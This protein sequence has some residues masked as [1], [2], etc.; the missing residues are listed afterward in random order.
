VV[1]FGGEVGSSR[2]LTPTETTAGKPAQ[3][4]FTM[5]AKLSHCWQTEI[6][7]M[8]SLEAAP[9]YTR[10]RDWDAWSK[11]MLF[12]MVGFYLTGRSFSYLGIP[13]A[14]L[15]IGDLTLA[16]FVIFRPRQLFDRWFGALTGGGPLGAFSWVL[17]ISV[18]YGLFETIRG[19]LSGF[20]P[21][22]ALQNLVFN[23]YPLYFFLGLWAG[24]RRPELMLRIVQVFAW[25]LCIYGPFYYFFLHNVTT[26][27]PGSDSVTVFGQA[28]GGAFVILALLC[29]DPKPSRYWLPMIMAAVTFLVAQVRADWFGAVLAFSIWGVLE[30]K[31]KPVAKFVLGLAALLLIG[32]IFDV[33]LPSSSSRGGA[34]STREI[35]A[36]GL[37]AVDPELAKDLTGSEDTA[38]YAGTIQWR[39]KWWHAIWEN[40]QENKTNFVIGPGYGFE[41]KKLVSYLNYDIRTPHNIFYFALGYSGWLGV[42]IFFALQIACIS[43]LWRLYRV[44]GQAFGLAAY[45]ATLFSAFFGNVLEN[46]FGAIP[47]YCM[48]GLLIG[49]NVAAMAQGVRERVSLGNRSPAFAEVNAFDEVYA[50]E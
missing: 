3:N 42:C 15:F 43:M 24:A 45:S 29:L 5:P 22:I 50:G 33:N 7:A 39:E 9:Q 4:F 38:M 2:N 21:L 37:S 48:M 25:G 31:M 1:T 34:I 12:F 44:T 28:T 40:S 32:V 20:S 8:S 47:L 36:R 30:R 6:T 23:L 41:L 49:P 16:A 14:K 35:V 11:Y 46:P 17:L 13:P 27:M 26:M 19:V 18:V 10:L